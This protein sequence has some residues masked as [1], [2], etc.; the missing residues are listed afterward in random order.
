MKW[1]TLVLLTLCWLPCAE[2]EDVKVLDNGQVSV[3]IDCDKGAA[4]TWLS[5]KVYPK[6]M[7]NL[8]DPG[9][10]IQQSYYAGNSL[11]RRRDGQHDAWSPWCW[12]PIQGGG[13]GSWAKTSKFSREDK[14]LFSETTPKLWD[15]PNEEAAAIMRQWTTFE[16]SLANTIRVQCEFVSLREDEDRWG[17]AKVRQQE[18][19]A[20]YFTRNFGSVKSYLGE[21]RWRIE[22]QPP[23]PPWGKATPPRKAMAVFNAEGLGVAVFSPAA[24]LPWNFGPHCAESESTDDPSAGPCMHVAPIGRVKLAS[25]S[26]FRYQYWLVVG[27]ESSIAKSLDSLWKKHSEERGELSSVEH[28]SP[29]VPVSITR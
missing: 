23:G 24:T 27:N 19:P 16:P 12:N 14:V 25:K 6:N 22:K 11:D 15:M 21:G 7:V 1:L 17:P 8:A 29:N 2:A 20:C 3:G 13:V 26:K 5:A 10:L 28:L 9:R 18:L 4:I